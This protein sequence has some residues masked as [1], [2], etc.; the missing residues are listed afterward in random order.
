VRRRR[1]EELT[2]YEEYAKDGEIEVDE[3]AVVSESDDGA[4]VQAWVWVYAPQADEE[5]AEVTDAVGR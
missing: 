5:E 1:S 2:R 4:Y 3:D